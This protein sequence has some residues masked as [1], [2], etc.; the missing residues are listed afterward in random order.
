MKI[1]YCIDSISRYGGIERVTVLK[2]NA[3]SEIEGNEI[4]IVVL[5]NNINYNYSVD[6]R[7][8]IVSLDVNYYD[9]DWGKNR[10]QQ[11][12]NIIAKKKEHKRKLKDVLDNIKPDI[13]ISTDK[14]EKHILPLLSRKLPSAFVREIHNTKEWHNCQKYDMYSYFLIKVGRYLDI[15]SMKKYNRIVFLTDEQ[16]KQYRKIANTAVRIP[17]P[18]TCLRDVRSNLKY[19]TVI[20]V[21]RL[22][23]NKNFKSL[24]RSWHYVHQIHPEWN[25]SIWGDGEEKGNIQRLIND[26]QLTE[27]V[28]LKGYSDDVFSKFVQSSIFVLTSLSESFGLVIIEAMSCGLPVVSYD[29]PYGPRSIITEGK[30]GFLVPMGDEQMLAERIIYLIEH[31][32]IRMQ[33]GAMAFEKSKQY[34]IDKIIPQWMD[35]FNEL[36]VEKCEIKWREN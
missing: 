28:F 23:R 29:S 35:L 26:S 7:V 11:I 21:G 9:H 30:D 10:V 4:W 13:V 18:F 25:L 3:L 12:I 20:S 32:D 36:L 5:D 16:K 24:I 2:A 22:E 6:K 1:V 31:E 15:K 8:H 27:T 14:M 19:K 33:M 34:S 17:N